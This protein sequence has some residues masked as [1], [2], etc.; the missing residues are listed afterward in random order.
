MG[1]VAHGRRQT[2]VSARA[3]RGI[4]ERARPGALAAGSELRSSSTA[5]RVE[6]GQKLTAVFGRE[7]EKK[8]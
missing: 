7:V 1:S 6:F 8:T 5:P 3:M 2:G 4:F